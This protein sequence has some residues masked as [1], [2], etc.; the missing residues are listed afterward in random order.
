MLLTISQATF[1]L[2]IFIGNVSAQTYLEGIYC[3]KVSCY[4][5]LEVERDAPKGEISKSYRRLAKKFHPDMHRGVEAKKEAEEKFKL[6]ATAYEILKDEESRADYDYMLD[7][8]EKIYS[9]YYR[10]YRRHVT[11]KVD[12]RIVVA[13]TITIISAV[14]YFSASQRYNSA[15]TYLSTVPKY[16]LKALDMAKKLGKFDTSKKSR[17]RTKNEMKEEEDMIIRQVLEDNID[18]RGGYAKPKVTDVLWIQLL[19]LP[20][21]IVLYIAWY[22]RWV[23]KFNIKKMEYGKEEKLYLIRKRLKMTQI[24]FDALEEEK[25]E[26][27]LKQELWIEEKY[28][29]WFTK[30]EE[31]MKKQLAENARYKACRRYMKNHGAGRITFD[32]S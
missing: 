3:G 21:N 4:G 10:Y 17:R 19:L 16:R 14:Q 6:I 9:H 31:D 2:A 5:V 13:V 30:R 25:R 22:L 28:Q 23:W 8:P 18:I 15:I 11:P 7:N 20:V 24:A 32:D 27:F 1:L 12:V 29:Q 26:T